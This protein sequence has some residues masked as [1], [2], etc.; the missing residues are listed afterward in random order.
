MTSEMK[1]RRALDQYDDAM[2]ELE[3]EH[4]ERRNNVYVNEAGEA[5][6]TDI[7]ELAMWREQ[8]EN[9]IKRAFIEALA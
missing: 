9:E 1:V 6:A 7:L 5:Y 4:R 3:R 8:R 2:A